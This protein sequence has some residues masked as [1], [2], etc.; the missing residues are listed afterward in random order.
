MN[1]LEEI[2]KLTFLKK[3]N[4]I[5][6]KPHIPFLKKIPYIGYLWESL[7]IDYLSLSFHICTFDK[8]YRYLEELIKITYDPLISPF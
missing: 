1:I 5:Y 4:L 8:N 6:T 2:V 7:F 3:Y